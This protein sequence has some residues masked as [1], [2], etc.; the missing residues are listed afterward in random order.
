MPNEE[1]GRLSS[2]S[3][4]RRCQVACLLLLVAIIFWGNRVFAL[5]E[6]DHRFTVEG[7]VCGS[8]GRGV[9]RAE[10]SVKDTRADV[11]GTGTT[12][13]HGY[14]KVLLHLHN[15]NQDDPLSVQSG[16]YESTGRVELDPHD[17]KTE[18]V[19]TVNL[20]NACLATPFWSNTVSVGGGAVLLGFLGIFGMKRLRQTKRVQQK[21]NKTRKK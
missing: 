16:E 7:W 13:G 21:K 1:K 8:D 5:H 10:V 14:F 4:A 17:S 15:E 20:G 11:A 2:F 18:R 6:V 3:E 9:E 19:I 12:D